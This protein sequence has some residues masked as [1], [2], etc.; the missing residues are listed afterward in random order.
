METN[1]KGIPNEVLH[2]TETDEYKKYRKLL[3]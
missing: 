3:F 1:K 2:I